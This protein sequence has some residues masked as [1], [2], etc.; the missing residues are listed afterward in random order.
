MV[1]YP[2]TQREDTT[3]RWTTRIIPAVAIALILFLGAISLAAM[4]G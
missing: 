4:P 3:V 1:I 2:L